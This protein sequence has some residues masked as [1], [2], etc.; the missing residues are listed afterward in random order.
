MEWAEMQSQMQDSYSMMI[1]RA[2]ELVRP[3]FFTLGTKRSLSLQQRCFATIQY[4]IQLKDIVQHGNETLVLE[5][6]HCHCVIWMTSSYFQELQAL[7][8]SESNDVH[9]TNKMKSNTMGHLK[10]HKV[11][12]QVVPCDNSCIKMIVQRTKKD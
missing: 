5:E 12:W 9:P 10:L 4:S 1:T 8:D 3:F 2:G 11:L 6:V 7:V